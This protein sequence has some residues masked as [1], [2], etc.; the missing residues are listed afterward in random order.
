MRLTYGE[1]EMN[2]IE[3]LPVFPEFR[4]ISL[5]DK[6]LMDTLLGE[7]QPQISELAFGNLF[8][9]RKS[10]PV[11]LS[12]IGETVLIQYRRQ[13][14]GSLILLPPFRK[15]SL[16]EVLKT[17]KQ[18]AGWNYSLPLLYGISTTEA[19]ELTAHKIRVEP[20][21]DEWDYVY[22]TRDLVDLS[23][24]KYHAKRNL[25]TQCLSKHRCEYTDITASVIDQCLQLQAKW[26]NLRNCDKVPSLAAE[27]Q[28]IKQLFEHYKELNVFGGVIYVD[29]ILEAFTV[30]ERLNNATAVIHIEKANPEIKGLYQVINQW[31]CQ[32]ALTDFEFVNREQDLGILGLRKAKK[33]YHPHHMVEKYKA[34]LT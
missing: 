12:R 16:P 1:V 10:E 4:A 6:Q 8:M 5:E 18:A 13:V 26:C 31:F 11:Q 22:L 33:S 14:D 3:T 7:E 24:D 21:R 27:N 23:G 2:R 32:R 9:W 34:Y 28:A 25:I 30:A 15:Q 19:E 29:G 20:C 17:L